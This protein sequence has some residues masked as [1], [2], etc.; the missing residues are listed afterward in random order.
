MVSL[1][2]EYV[3]P[4]TRS[5]VDSIISPIRLPEPKFC[6]RRQADPQAMTFKLKRMPYDM[7]VGA[8]LDYQ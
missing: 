3:E 4:K 7:I 6:A 1:K 8:D 2:V 5:I